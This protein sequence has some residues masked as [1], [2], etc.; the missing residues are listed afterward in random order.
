MATNLLSSSNT[1]N[2][3]LDDRTP[4]NS[5]E[6]DETMDIPFH[7]NCPKCR[8]LHTNTLFTIPSD[9]S[10]H[11]R[12]KCEEC[13]HQIFGIGRSSTQTTLA[14]IETI[15]Q[16]QRNNG[17]IRCTCTN[18]PVPISDLQPGSLR[19]PEQLN[20]G[21]LTP[22]PESNTVGGRSRATSLQGQNPASPGREAQRSR[23]TNHT[24]DNQI[25]RTDGVDHLG[26]AT[27]PLKKILYRFKRPKDKSAGIPNH[28]TSRKRDSTRPREISLLGYRLFLVR[29]S[30]QNPSQG[31]PARRDS[32]S[33]MQASLP[34]ETRENFQAPPISNSVI[35]NNQTHETQSQPQE[36]GQPE[37]DMEHSHSTDGLVNDGGPNDDGGPNAEGD[38]VQ[39][40]K[41]GIQAHR[42]EK[43]LVASRPKCVCQPGCPCLGNDHGSDDSSGHSRALLAASQVPDHSL[44]DIIDSSRSSGSP[45][46]Q[47]LSNPVQFA[48]IGNHFNASRTSTTE[49]S[50]SASG[51]RIHLN[52][53]SGAPTIYDSN[54]SNVSL[55]CGRHF[56]GRTSSISTLPPR[57]T[58]Q[59]RSYSAHAPVVQSH[60]SDSPLR[61]PEFDSP[62]T[63]EPSGDED[64]IAATSLENSINSSQIPHSQLEPEQTQ[65]TDAEIISSSSSSSHTLPVDNALGLSSEELTPR[66]RSHDESFNEPVAL[67]SAALAESLQHLTRGDH[68]TD[69]RPESL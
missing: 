36:I 6:N 46:S 59:D 32:G 49:E 61:N 48:G 57:S 5:D 28:P 27:S 44:H 11:T 67:S 63:S 31:I 41:N 19:G 56:G 66:P 42:R 23:D 22:I 34:T 62:I 38:A 8:H 12:F 7:G 17:T 26:T 58:L 68:A 29:K 21:Q 20:L 40:K 60:M 24:L 25:R 52:R 53:L 30:S 18:A 37:I 16:S 1:E 65:Q 4:R 39:A 33:L 3:P 54:D 55:P 9:R 2:P 15:P 13:S 50:S 64:A 35:P 10:K 43:T 69:S 47:M 45:N 51:S 14:S